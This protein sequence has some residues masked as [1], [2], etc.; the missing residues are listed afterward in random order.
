MRPPMT[1]PQDTPVRRRQQFPRPHRG[2]AVERPARP[3]RRPRGLLERAARGATRAGVRVLAVEQARQPHQHPMTTQRA[4]SLAAHELRPWPCGTAGHPAARGPSPGPPAARCPEVLSVPL[5]LE[6]LKRGPH[7]RR[8]H[9]PL[10]PR[11]SRSRL[12][13]HVAPARVRPRPLRRPDQRPSVARPRAAPRRHR[14][15]TI[16]PPTASSPTRMGT[17]STAP[18]RGRHLGPR[19]RSAPPTLEDRRPRQVW[20]P[21]PCLTHL[22]TDDTERGLSVSQ[23]THPS[24][25]MLAP[26]Q[27]TRPSAGRSSAPLQMCRP[28]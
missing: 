8:E 19:R 18:Q 24:S 21:G 13:L 26:S 20:S 15:P 3:A 14:A 10:P 23:D 1:L 28:P 2:P 4:R 9:W 11:P 6:P 7:R 17:P 22:H 12:S 16:A 5:P 25:S 27:S